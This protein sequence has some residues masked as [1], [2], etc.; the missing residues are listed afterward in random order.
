MPFASGSDFK[1]EPDVMK[2]ESW[3]PLMEVWNDQPCADEPE[4]EPWF[5]G[6]TEIQQILFPTHWV[7]CEVYNG[8]FYQY[9]TNTT[10]YH[11]LEAVI[12]FQKLG[13]DDV[14][15]IVQR[16]IDVFGSEFPRNRESRE[17]FLLKFDGAERSEWDPFFYLDDEFYEAMKIPGAPPLF[18]D[19]RFT[20]AAKKLVGYIS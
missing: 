12:G 14:A 2:N 17:S 15:Q 1:N 7:C 20:I 8:G 11:A 9:F 16:A 3:D 6:L 13:M 5:H 18:D 4:F 19:D 10:G